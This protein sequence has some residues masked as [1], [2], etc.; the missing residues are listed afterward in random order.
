MR[1]RKISVP[2]HGKRG[3]TGTSTGTGTGTGGHQDREHTRH[4]ARPLKQPRKQR[5]QSY[6]GMGGGVTDNDSAFFDLRYEAC[7]PTTTTHRL[8][9]AHKQLR[10]DDSRETKAECNFYDDGTSSRM[11]PQPDSDG[12]CWRRCTSC[13]VA[14]TSSNS[15]ECEAC[16]QK[17]ITEQ[18]DYEQYLKEQ[19]EVE[20]E[21]RRRHTA[22]ADEQEDL[23]RK[24]RE[25]FRRRQ[26]MEHQSHKAKKTKDWFGS[27]G[28]VPGRQDHQSPH[29]SPHPHRRRQSHEDDH[30][31][32]TDPFVCLEVPVGSSE[33]FMRRQYHKLCLRYHP[34]KSKHPQAND[35]FIAITEAYKKIKIR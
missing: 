9:D 19:R 8:P 12:R 30:W 34:D 16:I 4:P 25:R 5:S 22:T 26:F 21:Q 15:G 10:P 7:E 24:A 32:S 6:P 20:E 35:A 18:E 28:S 29:Q 14:M 17:K 11:S 31:R 13:E 27:S 3:G 2:L 23:F 33:A 1:R